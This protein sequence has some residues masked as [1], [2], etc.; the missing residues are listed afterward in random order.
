MVLQFCSLKPQDFTTGHAGHLREERGPT[1]GSPG[2]P[3]PLR[4]AL[5]HSKLLTHLVSIS[6]SSENRILFL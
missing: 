5:F 6:N 2:P 3:P 4:P 1:P